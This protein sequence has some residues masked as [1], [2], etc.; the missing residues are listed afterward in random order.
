MH[1]QR[2]T[3]KH[4]NKL[5]STIVPND[6]VPKLSFSPS[7]KRSEGLLYSA[8]RAVRS[9]SKAVQDL[10]EAAEKPESMGG[11]L[12]NSEGKFL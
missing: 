11:L 9:L 3:A 1:T 12:G 8:S 7:A 5:Q 6:W 10:S 4:G 2:V